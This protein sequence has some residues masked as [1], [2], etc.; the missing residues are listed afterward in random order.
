MIFCGWR[1]SFKSVALALAL[2]LGASGCVWLVVGG[3]GALGGYVI[4]PD[5]VE[6]VSSASQ[7]ELFGAALEITK[8]MGR[9]EDQSKSSGE[10]NAVI[11][12]AKVKVNVVAIN[13]STAKLRVKARKNFLPKITAAQDV[14]F[15][16]MEHLK[17]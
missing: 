10:I 9:I 2:A 11:G 6:G 5:T 14:Y 3:A 13:K 15:K 7:E 4:S 1:K 17:E 8:I 12:G 16:I